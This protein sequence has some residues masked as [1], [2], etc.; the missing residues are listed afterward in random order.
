MWKKYLFL[1]C[2]S[3]L[4]L[5]FSSTS[6]LFPNDHLLMSCPT[7]SSVACSSPLLSTG[8]WATAH[9]CLLAPSGRPAFSHPLQ[10]CCSLPMGVGK[11]SP[12]FLFALF[13]YYPQ[14]HCLNLSGGSNLYQGLAG[15]CRLGINTCERNGVEVGIGR[16]RNG[17]VMA[18]RTFLSQV[19]SS[20]ANEDTQSILCQANMSG[21]VF[22]FHLTQSLHTGCP[23]KGMTSGAEALCN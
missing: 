9:S 21:S 13:L 2:S 8:L 17:T 15:C 20:G 11:R 14:P 1:F 3:V 10:G 12:Y 22:M 5:F 4:L 16:K 23:G 18:S 6:F 19:E 7:S